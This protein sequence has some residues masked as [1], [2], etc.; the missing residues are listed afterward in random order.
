MSVKKR[1]NIICFKIEADA[2]LYK[3]IRG[4]VGT[5]LE[6]GKGKLKYQEVSKILDAKNRQKGGQNIP[7]KGLFLMQV[8]Y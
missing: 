7:A 5:L 2:F 3:M 1:G 8:K 6:A 4:I